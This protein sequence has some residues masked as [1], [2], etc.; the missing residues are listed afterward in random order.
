MTLT[1]TMVLNL[2][3]LLNKLSLLF[4]KG[5]HSKILKVKEYSW[6]R[7]FHVNVQ[8][9]PQQEMK[10][11]KILCIDIPNGNLEN[12]EFIGASPTGTEESKNFVLESKV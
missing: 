2:T 4:W 9:N 3:Y 10:S 1:S 8:Y 6:G 11:W 12:F 5:Y 7:K